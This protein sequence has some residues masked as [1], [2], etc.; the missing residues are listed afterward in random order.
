MKVEVIEIDYPTKTDFRGWDNGWRKMMPFGWDLFT[1]KPTGGS[2][3]GPRN[4][5]WSFWSDWSKCTCECLGGGQVFSSE[6]SSVVEILSLELIYDVPPLKT[7]KY[8]LK[9]DAWKVGNS[10]WNGPFSG[11]IRS[12]SGGISEEKMEL[13]HQIQ[14]LVGLEICELLDVFPGWWFFSC[15]SPKSGHG[16][17]VVNLK[18]YS[19]TFLHILLDMSMNRLSLWRHIALHLLQCVYVYVLHM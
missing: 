17:Q 18:V 2:C 5:L 15:D 11:D 12:F 4:C 8:H 7:N 16:L 9:N 10:I 14:H 6:L 3:P 1:L 13:L 19:H